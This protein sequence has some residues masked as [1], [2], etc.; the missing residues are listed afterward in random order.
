MNRDGH[1]VVAR[2]LMP[3]ADDRVTGAYAHL[4]AEAATSSP[5][6]VGQLDSAQRAGRLE[7]IRVEPGATAAALAHYDMGARTIS[8]AEGGL[9]LPQ[10]LL[11]QA[12]IRPDLAGLP[13]DR[14]RTAH[15]DMVVFNLGHESFHALH[16]DRL[17]AYLDEARAGID[18][19]FRRDTSAVGPD[20][21]PHVQRYLARLAAHEADAERMGWNALASRIEAEGHAVPA[22][23]YDMLIQRL[24][25]PQDGPGVEHTAP[26]DLHAPL[27]QRAA[28]LT[29]C[30]RAGREV[31]VPLA[32]PVQ[33]P[34]LDG[35]GMIP[36]GQADA[37]A[38]CTA[39][40]RHTYANAYI[41]HLMPL[42]GEAAH[43]DPDAFPRSFRLDLGSLGVD[44]SRLRLGGADLGTPGRF[45]LFQDGGRGTVMVDHFAPA[46]GAG[47]DAASDAQ[48]L[49][50]AGDRREPG[51]AQRGPSSS[52]AGGD[53]TLSKALHD[54]LRSR[55]PDGAIVSDAR[56][57][58]LAGIAAGSGI[59]AGDPVQLTLDADGITVR[60]R[61]PTHVAR[62]DFATTGAHEEAAAAPQREAAGAHARSNAP[63]PPHVP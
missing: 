19:G 13:V 58:Q 22:N 24:G 2:L 1:A 51:A 27:R 40:P 6:L 23:L 46:T 61:H 30:A 43:P 16:A 47:R 42:M 29:A 21:T 7:R 25:A 50:A 62:L 3:A 18:A 59:R 36:P 49:P 41:H 15:H 11:G 55:I 32:A 44:A 4:V 9:A 38:R 54:A 39:M 34:R 20:L 53:A 8:L 37:A 45:L 33:E 48:A 35:H 60:G 31:D 10:A 63:A 12:H 57:R 5:L 17:Q 52:A 56:L 28:L 26:W 14:I